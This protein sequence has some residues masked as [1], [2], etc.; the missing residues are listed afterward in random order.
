MSR[1]TRVK[2]GCV[3]RRRLTI[4]ARGSSCGPA[5]GEGGKPARS[6]NPKPLR[7]DFNSVQFYKTRRMLSTGIMANQAEAGL[8]RIGQAAVGPRG[9]P[10]FAA[11]ILHAAPVRSRT[12]VSVPMAAKSPLHAHFAIP[13]TPSSAAYPG[14][15]ARIFRGIALGAVL[16]QL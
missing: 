4:S 3:K 14:K 7:A 12:G 13:L 8:N 9:S 15:S 1:T 10:P 6:A 2:F 16:V 11:V 5:R